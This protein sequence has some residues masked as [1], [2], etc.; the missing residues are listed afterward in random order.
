[1]RVEGG[2]GLDFVI[3]GIDQNASN[4]IDIP[5]FHFGLPPKGSDAQR[6]FRGSRAPSPILFCYFGRWGKGRRRTGVRFLDQ[7]HC[8]KFVEKINIPDVVWAF[9]R[10]DLLRSKIVA[11]VGGCHHQDCCVILGE[12][13]R[14]E[15]G[16][17]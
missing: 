7:F 12:G 15:G 11:Q 10:K 9:P 4:L 1:M 16:Q 5:N 17:G 14:A 3:D 13:Q 2:Q 6:I 8:S